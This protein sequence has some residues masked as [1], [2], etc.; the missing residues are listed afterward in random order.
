MNVERAS[1]TRRNNNSSGESDGS[2]PALHKGTHAAPTT[3]QPSDPYS[4]GTG[5]GVNTA[6]GVNNEGENSPL[7]SARKTTKPHSQNTENFRHPGLYPPLAVN[8][9][10]N[11]GLVYVGAGEDLSDIPLASVSRDDKAK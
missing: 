7:V 3:H 5:T 11:A 2:D 9:A 1:T 10:V 6:G 4:K 8:V